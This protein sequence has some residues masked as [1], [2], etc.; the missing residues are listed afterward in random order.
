MYRYVA[1]AWNPRNPG[2]AERVRELAKRLETTLPD[3][4]IALSCNG[5]IVYVSSDSAGSF[6]AYR[7]T[8]HNVLVLGKLFHQ[9]M[10]EDSVPARV[11]LD[12]NATRAIYESH[13]RILL[14]RYWGGYVA[15][16]HKESLGTTFVIRDPTAEIPCCVTRIGEISV[17]FSC[18]EDCLA[19]GP[20]KFSINWQ[21]LAAYLVRP[22]LP[23]HQTGFKEVSLV[24]PG[25]CLQLR[26]GIERNRQYYWDIVKI[27]AEN[28]I[29]SIDEAVASARRTI[30]GS[31]AALAAGHPHVIHQ[32][33][34]G[35]DSSTILAALMRAPS[36]PQVTCIHHFD[37]SAGSDER[38]FARLAVQGAMASSGRRCELIEYPRIPAAVRFD[39]T[40]NFPRTAVPSNYVAYLL[41]RHFVPHPAPDGSAVQF[42]GHAGDA[43]YGRVGLEAAAT[44]YV[45]RH[46]LG[47]NLLRIAFEAAQDGGTVY[48]VLGRAIR[49]G[50][51]KRT[52]SLV[53]FKTGAMLNRKI[54]EAARADRENVVPTWLQAAADPSLVSPE[55]LYHIELMALPW[56]LLL[57]PFERLGKWEW[58]TP[59]TAQCVVEL[60]ARIPLYVLMADGEERTIARRAFAADLPPQLLARRTKSYSNTFM[61]TIARQHEAFFRELYCNGMLVKEGLLERPIV[62]DILRTLQTDADL[63][64]RELFGP[65]LNIEIWLRRWRQGAGNSAHAIAA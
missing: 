59:L 29:E 55:K 12:G 39:Q 48:G 60:F 35:L 58:R 65:Q 44:D 43:V 30:R 9:E 4:G 18:M 10:A 33:S 32:L 47:R 42:A 28:P 64:A 8:G 40:D 25:E 24:A 38:S 53:N 31:V 2:D 50:L 26:D 56:T 46:G 27:S 19:L 6:E 3:P 61:S 34:G 49:D 54:L 45:W 15:F 22:Y 63:R 20:P 14:E 13:G 52:R 5:L 7:G 16:V 62:E 1:L 21:Y 36:Q 23:G 51:L 17:I 11:V 37:T 41:E 57:D